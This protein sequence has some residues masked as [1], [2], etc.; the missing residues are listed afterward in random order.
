MPATTKP[1][2]VFDF[3]GVISNSFHDSL[4]M[5]LST[6]AEIV[7]KHTLPIESPMEP[8]SIFA[9]EKQHTE[10]TSQFYNLMP[11]GNLARDYYVILHILEHG[12]FHQ[13]TDQANYDAYKAAL[14]YNTI[15]AYDARFYEKR[16]Q[17]QESDPY[18]WINLVPCFQGIPEAIKKL[19]SKAELAIATSKDMQ[20]VTML[21]KSYGLSH[22]FN[23][24]RILDKDFAPTKRQHLIRLAEQSNTPYEN[25]FFI[26]DK[27]LH[28]I[29][30]VDLGIN[31]Y[32]AA[33]GFNTE[34]EAQ[35][36]ID[37][38]CSILNLDNL[39]DI[40]Q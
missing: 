28:L 37:H 34:R 13:I 23:A 6:Y 14:N 11:M 26:D 4:W 7:Q 27:V 8:E 40:I 35:V 24:D 31:T 20:S 21:L 36:A 22:F 29:D 25:I 2:I 18:T 38:G 33:W 12:K 30:T 19:Y 15:M 39:P 17:F 5:G 1:L 3:D 32:L 9:F 16:S 10:L